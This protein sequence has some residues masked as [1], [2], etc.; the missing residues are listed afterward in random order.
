DP[1]FLTLRECTFLENF[2]NARCLV[3]H[4]LVF[5]RIALLKSRDYVVHGLD[6]RKS[7]PKLVPH[8]RQN[9]SVIVR[10]PANCRRLSLWL[11]SAPFWRTRVKWILLLIS[12]SYRCC[13]YVR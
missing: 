6:L 13:H 5:A 1:C 8:I 3:R 11:R 12:A 10:S 2:E 7:R 9:S 4:E